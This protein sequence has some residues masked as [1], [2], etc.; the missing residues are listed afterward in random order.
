MAQRTLD[1]LMEVDKFEEHDPRA[2]RD[3]RIVG[4][5]VRD[6]LIER[7]TAKCVLFKPICDSHRAL[8]LFTEHPGSR[9]IW[10]YRDYRDVANSS[11]EYWGDQ[12]KMY[13]EDLLDGGG[14]WGVSQWNREKVTDECLDEIRQACSDGLCPHGACALFWYMRNRLYFRQNLQDRSDTLLVRYEDTVQKPREEFERMCRF[15]GLTFDPSIVADIFATSL[16]RREFPK[17]SPRIERLCD[18]MMD[19]LDRAYAGG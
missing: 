3:C 11:V 19:R 13:I 1:R 2:F 6:A 17:I 18:G 4:K 15:L 16:R 12:T 10:I 8:E 9:A 7:S 5:E 14:D